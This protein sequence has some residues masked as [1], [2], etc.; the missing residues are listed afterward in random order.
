MDGV[1]SSTAAA[2]PPPAAD[3]DLEVV[4][5]VPAVIRGTEQ[6]TRVPS[7]RRALREV[8]PSTATDRSRLR[9]ASWPA[10]R[11]P[12][13]VAPHADREDPPGPTAGQARPEQGLG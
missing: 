6:W 4:Q 11:V 10:W 9:A 3:S 1:T 8:L 13:A 7:A 5:Q 12:G 2:P